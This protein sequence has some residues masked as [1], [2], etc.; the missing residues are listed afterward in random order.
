MPQKCHKA[1]KQ[2]AFTGL[3]ICSYRD[4]LKDHSTPDSPSQQKGPNKKTPLFKQQGA[5]DFLG[6][7]SPG[8]AFPL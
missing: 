1:D 2:E 3:C 6:S 4:V 5:T 7:L 8:A